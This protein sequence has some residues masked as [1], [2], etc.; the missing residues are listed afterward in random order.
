MK[1]FFTSLMFLL[2]LLIFVGCEKARPIVDFICQDQGEGRYYFENRTYW[3]DYKSH[4][5]NAAWYV[6]GDQ[7]FKLLTGERYFD[8]GYY[9]FKTSG[10]HTVELEIYDFDTERYYYKK[11]PFTSRYQIV[12]PEAEIPVAVLEEAPTILNILLQ[13]LIMT[14]MTILK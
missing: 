13:I 7:V 6:D 9:T 14:S 11:K 12:A 10:N 1:K 8:D 3:S 4:N 2:T 5:Y